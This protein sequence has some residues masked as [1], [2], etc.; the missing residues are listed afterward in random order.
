MLLGT[1]DLKIILLLIELRDGC[2]LLDLIHS[3]FGSCWGL[4]TRRSLHY[5]LIKKLGHKIAL[6]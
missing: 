6:W 5:Y 4:K 3:G 1:V 2:D